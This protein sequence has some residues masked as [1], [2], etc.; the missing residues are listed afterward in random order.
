MYGFRIIYERNWERIRILGGRHGK[1][2]EKKKKKIIFLCEN[3]T[4]KMW[5]VDK[6]QWL[7]RGLYR[8]IS[9]G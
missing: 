1:L 5:R 3:R 8:D 9:G 7:G 2:C 4:G 6:E